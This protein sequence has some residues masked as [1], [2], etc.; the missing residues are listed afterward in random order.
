ME[1]KDTQFLSAKGKEKVLRDWRRFLRDGL[2]FSEFTENLYNHLI[3]H[4]EFIAHYDRQGFYATYFVE[5]EDTIRFFSQFDKEKGNRS[6]EY[7][8][9]WWLQ[10]D[11]EDIN[12]AM[13]E[14]FERC[15]EEIY[16]MLNKKLLQVRVKRARKALRDLGFD[17]IGD[18]N[19]LK[20]VEIGGERNENTERS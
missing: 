7:G 9:T 5:P 3:Q 14:E 2:K 18:E 6:V 16:E 10:G 17:L 4:C 12:K 19:G 8:V 15:K 20:L 1:F 13:I 11:Y